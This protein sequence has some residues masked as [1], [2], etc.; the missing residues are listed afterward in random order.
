VRWQD[1]NGNA[2]INHYAPL[3]PVERFYFRQDGD[4]SAIG[5]TYL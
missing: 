3:N 1:G 4:F 2:Q 5:A